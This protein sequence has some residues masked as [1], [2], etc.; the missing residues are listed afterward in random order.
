MTTVSEHQ[1]QLCNS[2][3]FARSGPRG[4]AF[5]PAQVT[6]KTTWTPL[7]S[8][9]PRFTIDQGLGRQS[10]LLKPIS[11]PVP[12]V[13]HVPIVF[14]I[15]VPPPLP[16]KRAPYP[17]FHLIDGKWDF[18]TTPPANDV[19]DVVAVVDE[20]LPEFPETVAAPVAASVVSVDVVVVDEALPEFPGT[21]DNN[22]VPFVVKVLPEF[23]LPELCAPNV[24]VKQAEPSVD[25]RK[26]FEDNLQRMWL[27]VSNDV[28]P[29]FDPDFV[30]I[31]PIGEFL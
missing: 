26:E 16:P 2:H 4:V 10:P 20:S 28:F 14:V 13:L 9:L 3:Y 27:E 31:D 11:A 25:S 7:L 5:K 12:V 21:T 30:E 17:S 6:N 15:P 23:H 22:V 24:E 8:F 1:K 19:V 29:G 18:I